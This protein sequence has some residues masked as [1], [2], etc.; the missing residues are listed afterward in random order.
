MI[1][2]MSVQTI[3]FLVLIGISSGILSGFVGVGGGIIIVPALV[4]M[5]G[6][7]QHQAQ[8]TSLFILLLPVGILAV[9]NYMKAGHINWGYGIVVS[10]TF[11]IGGYIGSKLSLKLSPHAVKFVFGII[12]ILI[13]IKLIVSGYNGIQNER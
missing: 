6:M 9:M 8:G 2:K 11:V 3:L 4:F 13:S 7:T 5:L 1:F 12:M 10:L